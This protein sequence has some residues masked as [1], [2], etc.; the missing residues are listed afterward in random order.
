MFGIF[1]IILEISFHNIW[2]FPKQHKAIVRLTAC[3]SVS[4]TSFM[5][6]SFHALTTARFGYWRELHSNIPASKQTPVVTFTHLSNRNT[7]W[8]ECM[9][10]QPLMTLKWMY[11]ERWS[12]ENQIPKFVCPSTEARHD[13]ENF[14]STLSSKKTEG[15]LYKFPLAKFKL[16]LMHSICF[17]LLILTPLYHTRIT[18]C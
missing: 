16:V 5:K 14:E 4:Q 3:P 7:Q 2:H 8:R 6:L 17:H 15:D 18:C 11:I 9:T 10:K 13:I 12:L 1:L